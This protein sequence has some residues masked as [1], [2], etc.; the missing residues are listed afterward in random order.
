GSKNVKAIV[1]NASKNI[2]GSSP[3]IMKQVRQS[4]DEF[5][6]PITNFFRTYGTTGITNGSAM[7]GD[8]P[9][10]NWGGVGMVDFPQGMVLSG[11]NVNR[12]MEKKYACWH[13]PVACG[14]ESHAWDDQ[15]NQ[16]KVR[17]AKRETKASELKAQLAS[18]A[19]DQKQPL[20][21]QL[22]KI[23]NDNKADAE[24][25]NDAR[26]PYPKHTHRAEY[27]T[28]T[29]FGTMMLN[30]DIN[31]L[32]YANHL[33]NQYGVDTIAAG[34]TVAFAMECYENGLITKEDTDGIDLRWGNSD[35]IIEALHKIGKKE[36]SLGEIFG[37]GVKAASDKI[38]PKS[39]EFAMEVGGEELPMHDPKLQPEY[40]T[41]YK[42]DPTPARHTQYEGASRP[43]WNL[44][45]GVQNRTVAAG[46]GDHHQGRAN[47]MHVVNSAG[48]CMFIMMG[49]PNDRIPEWI[50]SETG[51]DTTREELIKTG[52]RIGNLRMAF[53][54]R[55]GDIVT[56]RR[57]PGRLWGAQALEAGPHKDLSLDTKTLEQE[58]LAA[59]GW[60]AATAT[61]SR[62]KLEELEIGDVAD[63]IGAK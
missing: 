14:G 28:M 10:K 16:A 13:C 36:G 15:E 35:A 32:H 27:E 6:K 38:G 43:A 25:A 39:V 20:E 5:A 59:A 41:T 44:A 46:R 2:I 7:S 24:I 31:A 29:S 12:R 51:W 63:A 53:S 8:A 9:V 57:V 61:P 23:E 33:C 47:Y 60:D 19:D 62:K 45:P 4:L 56:Q 22:K 18:A 1:V 3:E 42:L 21:S 50:N 26:Y 34:A 52:E 55:E 11:D 17:I 49:A 58:F 48:M 40:F 54:V 30:N 37:D